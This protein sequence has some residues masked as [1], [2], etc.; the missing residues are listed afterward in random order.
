MRTHF[1]SVQGIS[2]AVEF[3]AHLRRRF[4]RSRT[5]SSAQQNFESR[6]FPAGSLHNLKCRGATRSSLSLGF[7]FGSYAPR[8][9]FVLRTTSLRGWIAAGESHLHHSLL[10]TITEKCASIFREVARPL[11]LPR[12]LRPRRPH[13]LR[14]LHLRRRFHRSRTRSSA[15]WNFE[16]RRFPHGF[17]TQPEMPGRNSKL[18]LLGFSF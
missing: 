12:S 6:R 17:T 13:A 3:E 2:P 5:R 10:K 14:I 9:D 16:S 1:L 8:K 7:S 11:A 15:K 18:A 4:L